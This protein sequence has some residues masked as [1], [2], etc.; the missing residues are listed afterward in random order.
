MKR[1]KGKIITVTSSK[2]G[3]GKTTLLLNLVGIYSKLNKKVL[4]L[5][6]D[7]S[8]GNIS[9]NLN[10]EV[11]KNI[12]HVA[13]D[14]HNNRYLSYKDYVFKYNENID[15]VGSVKDPRCANKI[16]VKDLE[17]FLNEVVYHYDVILIDTIHG[18]NKNNV[19]TLDLTDR[20]LYV[21]SNDFMDI[22]NT[23]NFISIM[24][25]VGFENIKMVLNESF[26]PRLEYF[27]SFD[28]KSITKKN[29]DYTVSSSFYIRN[30]ESYIIEGK[31]YTLT[32][33]SNKHKKDID[34]LNHMA[35]SL[36]EEEG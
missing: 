23:K 17:L 21:V 14:I 18:L 11:K 34:K 22:K 25:G 3:V 20:I 1:E 30:I 9:L 35:L 12:Y 6:F 2:G 8:S 31:I 5:D 26:N 32:N 36:L 13:D 4:L 24:N 29:I 15:V 19:L 33:D 7:F 16:D 10:L 28:I 27:N